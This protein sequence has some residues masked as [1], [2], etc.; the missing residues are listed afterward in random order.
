[1]RVIEERFG[2][3]ILY[4]KFAVNLLKATGVGIVLI[5]PVYVA[6]K[7]YM[8]NMT[9][10]ASFWEGFWVALLAG[11]AFWIIAG[12]IIWVLYSVV[13]YFLRNYT[14]PVRGDE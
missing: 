6:F 13:G 5:S 11:V 7:Y 12:I 2:R 4:K 3:K 1:M 8:D 9:H 14:E 10:F